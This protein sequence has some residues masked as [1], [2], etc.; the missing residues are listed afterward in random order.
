MVRPD[1]VHVNIGTA[2]RIGLAAF[3][4]QTEEI[5]IVDHPEKRDALRG[6]AAALNRMRVRGAGV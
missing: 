6:V 2:G 4:L 1:R 5:V 3:C